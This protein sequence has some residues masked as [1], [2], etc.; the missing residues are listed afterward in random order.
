MNI[1]KKLDEI[2]PHPRKALP[3][4]PIIELCEIIQELNW[5]IE[6]L[7]DELSELKQKVWLK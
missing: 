6:N 4:I 3:D 2:K 5:K 7:E 1:R